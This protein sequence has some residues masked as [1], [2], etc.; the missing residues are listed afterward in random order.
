[1]L[2]LQMQSGD[3]LTIDGSIV[4]QVFRNG[5]TIQVSVQAPKE[6]PIVRGKLLERNGYQRPEGLLSKPSKSP[7]DQIRSARM[8]E[9]M[10]DR[11]RAAQAKTATAERKRPPEETGGLPKEGGGDGDDRAHA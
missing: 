11:Q 8:F 7:S 9:R 3:Y 4:V 6:I 10:V 5:S 1:M 2:S